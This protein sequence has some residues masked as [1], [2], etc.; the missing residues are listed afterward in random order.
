MKL[1][2]FK[3]LEKGDIAMIYLNNRVVY[4]TKISNNIAETD[5]ELIYTTFDTM[6][7]KKDCF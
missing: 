1:V 4:A 5:S 6:C 3:D 7:E 2:K